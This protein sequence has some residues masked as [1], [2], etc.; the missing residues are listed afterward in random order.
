MEGLLPHHLLHLRWGLHPH[1]HK[2]VQG[3][4]HLH[5]PL[6]HPMEGLLP[7][8]L[9]HPVGV[10]HPHHLLHPVGVQGV[11]L[12]HLLLRLWVGVEQKEAPN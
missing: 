2:E 4:P 3:V 5:L 9:L 10:L 7:H 6:L 1:L 8:H 11:P 12:P